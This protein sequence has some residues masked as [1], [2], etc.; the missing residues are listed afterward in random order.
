MAKG[1]YT[2]SVGR[3]K[4]S[5]AQI[6][7]YK[8]AGESTVNGKKLEELFT[9]QTQKGEL[10][11]P[12]VVTENVGNYFFEAKVTGGGSKGQLEAVRHALSRALI[13]INP[14]YKVRLKEEGFTTRDPR[15][16]ERKKPYTRGARRGKQFS[17]R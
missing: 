12:L 6:K 2:Y 10:L 5:T 4:T 15:M 7:V 3:R 1:K 16:K 17:K 9:L 11:L 8:G 13:V 14:D